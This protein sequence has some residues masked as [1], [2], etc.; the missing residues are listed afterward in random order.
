[1]KNSQEQKFLKA[2]KD[3]F[4]GA[5][6]EGQS[7]YVNL[8]HIKSR[9]FE[10][11]FPIL[12]HDIDEKL[13]GNTDFR[14]ELF[15]KLYF[16]FSRYF[17]ETGS[18]YFNYTPL[19]QNIYD[20]VYDPN[21]DVILFWKTHMLY[22]VKSEAIYKSMSIEVEGINFYFDA[23]QIENKKNNERR[24]LI[25]EFAKV[26]ILNK[27]STILFKVNYS[28][29]GRLTKVYEILKALKK[30]EIKNLTEEILEQSFSIFK[31]QSEVDFFINKNAKEFLREQFDLY[32]YQY[33]FKE[34]NQFDDKR[35][36]E[37]QSLKEIAYNIIS[38]ISQFEDELVKIWNKPKFPLNS[39]YVITLDRLSKEIIEK[40]IKHEG[41][42]EQ[43]AEWKQLGVVKDNLN[44]RYYR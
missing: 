44:K 3:V 2:L 22:Y 28:Q 10:S 24:D 13:K 5:K 8:M 32:I 12:M 11:I 33:M 27:K 42:K 15:E 35:I 20:K 40:I 14:E 39:N 23:S 4:I 7:G 31:K 34:I 36:K 1:M 16:F 25:F 38:F 6:I 18:I 21:R 9:Y 37:L 17:N 30:E 41:I 43:I 29:R 19:Y 26:E